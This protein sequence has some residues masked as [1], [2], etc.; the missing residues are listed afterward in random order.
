MRP[1][2][3]E[4]PF[5]HLTVKS[6]GMMMVIGFLA[7]VFLMRKMSVRVGEDPCNITNIALY[8]LIT[9]VLGARLFYVIHNFDRFRGNLLN[10][11]SVWRGGLEFIGGVILAI[12]FLLVFLFVKKFSIR[13]YLDI[14]VV[15]LMLGLA[16]SANCSLSRV[17]RANMQSFSKI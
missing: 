6:Y 1:E 14:L 17:S 4:L 16:Y 3:F 12:V 10:I 2:L 8:A 7:A 15:G 11:F 9:G 13:R 5:I